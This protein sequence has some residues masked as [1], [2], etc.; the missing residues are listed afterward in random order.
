MTAIAASIL[1]YNYA[2]VKYYTDPHEKIRLV[3]VA[4]LAAL[5][6]TSLH[7]LI[8]PLDTEDALSKNEAHMLTASEARKAA[9]EQEL[10]QLILSKLKLQ[11]EDLYDLVQLGMIFMLFVGLPLSFFYAFGVQM[12]EE[13]NLFQEA[14][15]PYGNED[16]ETEGLLDDE[17]GLTFGNTP[18][19]EGLDSSSE[20]EGDDD[21]GKGNSGAKQK[22]GATLLEQL[23]RFVCGKNKSQIAL[24]TQNAKYAVCQTAMLLFMIFV[25]IFG[26]FVTIKLFSHHVI[27]QREDRIVHT[28]VSDF[29]HAHQS[30]AQ[31]KDFLLAMMN[32]VGAVLGAIYVSFGMTGLP[33][34]LIKGTRSLEDESDEL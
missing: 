31:F 12:A 18:G 14:E 32:T 8:L 22:K 1:L 6:L 25:F 34:L 19:L 11:V 5:S 17:D 24:F 20:E 26:A 28:V 15:T 27:E 33:F 7:A 21:N 23:T 3:V 16:M 4:Q 29:F 30:T 13:Q 9:D 2:L 10:P